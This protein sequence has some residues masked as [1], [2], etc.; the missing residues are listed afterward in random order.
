MMPTPDEF[1]LHDANWTLET[2][3]RFWDHYNAASTERY[4]TEVVGDS[5]LRLV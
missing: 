1:T 5:I 3:G 2:I 4:F